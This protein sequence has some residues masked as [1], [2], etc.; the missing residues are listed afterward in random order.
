[1]PRAADSLYMQLR[2]R[3]VLTSIPGGEALLF[4]IGSAGL[5]YF[6]HGIHP[7]HMIACRMLAMSMIYDV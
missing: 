3:R 2:D 6:H 7:Y 1:M 5:M 4:M